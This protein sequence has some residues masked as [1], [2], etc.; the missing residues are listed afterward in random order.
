MEQPN[1]IITPDDDTL[2]LSFV[3]RFQL[4]GDKI[5]V[6]LGNNLG[7]F[8]SGSNAII[9]YT[10]ADAATAEAAYVVFQNALL[11][12]GRVRDMRT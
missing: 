7:D 12:M 1:W 11:S 2:N 9:T 3:S 8:T 6:V 5:H 10:Y 4:D